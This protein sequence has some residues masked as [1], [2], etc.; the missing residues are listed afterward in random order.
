[1]TSALA[2]FAATFVTVFALAIQSL[3]TNGGHKLLAFITSFAIGGSHLVLYKVL[4]GPT[5]WLQ[6]AA[7]L[8]G[9]PFGIVSAML[10]HPWLVRR[11]GRRP[12]PWR[13]PPAT[14]ADPFEALCRDVL[15]PE[16]LGHV[17]HPAIRNRARAAFGL[18]TRE[19]E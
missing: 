12:P 1:M 5:D 16:E 18:Q 13:R 17:A 8:L 19:P 7:Y 6:N 2:I 3:N 15:D 11:L 9:G 14:A 4:P 10:A